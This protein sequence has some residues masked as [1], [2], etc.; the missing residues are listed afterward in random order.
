MPAFN[1]QGGFPTAFDLGIPVPQDVLTSTKNNFAV[2]VTLEGPATAGGL[3][4]SLLLASQK[5]VCAG[6]C[7]SHFFIFQL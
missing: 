7:G 3:G 1:T 4:Q 6:V 5:S 2:T